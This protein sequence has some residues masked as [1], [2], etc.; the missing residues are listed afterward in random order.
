[1]AISLYIFDLSATREAQF[2]T[3]LARSLDAWTPGAS[4]ERR[5]A[6]RVQ[7][8]NRA[9]DE[10]VETMPPGDRAA[11]VRALAASTGTEAMVAPFDVARVDG[12][13]ARATAGD[14]ATVLI[15]RYLPDSG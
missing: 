8:F 7:M 5:G 15:D 3:F 1:M 2:R 6:R 11:L 4:S 10:G 9:L 13:L 12:A 14:I